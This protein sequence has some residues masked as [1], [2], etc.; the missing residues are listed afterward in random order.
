MPPPER[1]GEANPVNAKLASALFHKKPAH[2]AAMPGFFD[3]S[4]REE[5]RSQSCG[6]EA[7]FSIIPSK[8]PAPRGAG[9]FDDDSCRIDVFHR[10][11]LYTTSM[12]VA[13][14]ARG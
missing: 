6:C 9:F 3:A 4:P 5:R 10:C 2:R 1:I 8:I 13:K 14:S 7:R 11:R 12:G